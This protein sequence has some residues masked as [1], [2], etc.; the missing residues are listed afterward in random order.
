MFI[1][2][3]KKFEPASIPGSTKYG[4]SGECNPSL[5]QLMGLPENV[6]KDLANLGNFHIAKN[7]WSTYKTAERLLLMCQAEYKEKFDWPMTTKDVLLF[8]HWLIYVR[9][10]KAGTVKS[11]L[12]GI[13]Q[14]HIMKGLDEPNL[15]PEI[16]KI[17]IK[18]K[19]NKDKADK[20]RK[21]G[22]SRLPMTRDL[23]KTL[24]DKII[25]WDKPWD[26][27]LLVWAV[28]TLAF[29]G[30]FR[31]HELLCKTESFFDPF[32]TLL[33]ENVTMSADSNGKRTIHVKLNCP[34]EQ[35]NG[36]A[37]IIDIFESGCSICPVKAFTRWTAIQQPTNGMPLFRQPD[38]TPLTGKKLNKILDILMADEAKKGEG[39]I[40]SHSFRIGIASELGT[41]G[42][43][44]EEVMATGRWS[45]RAFES[46]MRTPRTKRASMARKI[47]EMGNRKRG[48]KQ[49]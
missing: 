45:S 46:Y 24:K 47:A 12:S 4:S 18:G 40:K 33:T 14:L 21:T 34:K 16:V 44:D 22:D 8:V 7:T 31:I 32:Y 28:C 23:M 25:S 10:L 48:T 36:Q 41:M 49:N 11:Y 15:R 5:F 13:R 3:G 35:R 9:N 30:A 38:G 39:T 17:V 29:H 1:F 2:A 20:L 27:K 26:T 43:D 6:T 37:V 42:F 19:E